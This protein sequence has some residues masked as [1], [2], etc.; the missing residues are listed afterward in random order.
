MQHDGALLLLLALADHPN[1]TRDAARAD[2]LVVPFVDHRYWVAAPGQ[3]LDPRLRDHHRHLA[4]LSGAGAGARENFRDFGRA[5]RDVAK[6]WLP[7]SE[8]GRRQTSGR[9]PGTRRSARACATA[10]RCGCSWGPRASASGRGTTW[11]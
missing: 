5:F 6:S 9:R 1:R 3:A 7:T 11:C 2:F 10:R 8:R 4:D